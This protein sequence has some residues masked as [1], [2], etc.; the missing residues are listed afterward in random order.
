MPASNPSKADVAELR[1]AACDYLEKMSKELTDL[2][3]KNDFNS[4]AMIFEM[5]RQE[6]ERIR[7]SSDEHLD[8][9]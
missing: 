1:R 2:A 6:A 8:R 5:A 4:L 3:F 7:L 9:P